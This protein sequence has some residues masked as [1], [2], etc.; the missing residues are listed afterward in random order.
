MIELV[1][2][3][4]LLVAETTVDEPTFFDTATCNAYYGFNEDIEKAEFLWNYAQDMDRKD[5]T[6][7]LTK[8]SWIAIHQRV[9]LMLLN[10]D[11][12][13]EGLNLDTRCTALYDR[14]T[15]SD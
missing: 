4:Y 3:G 6:E 12:Y 7:S 5:D 9:Y 1:L 14:L 15:N 11:P 13:A 8:D 2:A 10:S